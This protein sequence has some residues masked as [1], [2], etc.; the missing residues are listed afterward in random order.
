MV[1]DFV[2]LEIEFEVGSHQ[3]HLLSPNEKL[4]QQFLLDSS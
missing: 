3:H 2:L 1:S 4:I